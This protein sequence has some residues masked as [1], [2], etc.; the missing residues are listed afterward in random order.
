MDADDICLEGRFKSQVDFLNDHP[1]VGVLGTAY[2]KFDSSGLGESVVH[3]TDHQRIMEELLL[4]RSVIAH[5]TAMIRSEVLKRHNIS[6]RT[7]MQYCE[8][9]DLWLQLS[10]VTRFANLASV[11]LLYRQSSSSISQVFR[12]QQAKRHLRTRARFVELGFSEA[13][14]RWGLSPRFFASVVRGALQSRTIEFS[15]NAL[16]WVL[17]AAFYKIMDKK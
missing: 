13:V 8:D 5:P 14:N 3:P 2:R 15:L 6:Y 12:E 1:E 17:R 11:E 9:Y 10:R 7:E 16:R 4:G